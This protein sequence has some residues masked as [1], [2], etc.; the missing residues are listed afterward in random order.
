MGQQSTHHFW[1]IHQNLLQKLHFDLG[2]HFDGFLVFNRFYLLLKSV[3]S[4]PH[5]SD[6]IRRNAMYDCF[7]DFVS[8]L[9]WDLTIYQL[10]NKLGPFLAFWAIHLLISW[11]ITVVAVVGSV[12]EIL[13]EVLQLIN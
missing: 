10:A 11:S 5:E 4:S 6:H 1:L 8:V 13:K 7:Y 3:V 2:F 9:K 12:Y